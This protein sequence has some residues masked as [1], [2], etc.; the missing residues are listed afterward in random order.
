MSMNALRGLEMVCITRHGDFLLNYAGEGQYENARGEPVKDLMDMGCLG[1]AAAYFT[2]EAGAIDFCPACGYME[3]KQFKTF[4]DLQAWSNAQHWGFLKRN[5][6]Q[7]FGA[8]RQGEWR[9]VFAIEM[10]SVVASGHFEEVREL[11]G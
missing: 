3:R 11:L 7:A 1:C 10:A 2:T 6:H 4:Q 5:G 8:E 9:L